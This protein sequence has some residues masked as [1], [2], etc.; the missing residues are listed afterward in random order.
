MAKEERCQNR[1]L[2]SA[3]N[4]HVLQEGLASIY[5]RA[6]DKTN[7]HGRDDLPW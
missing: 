3:Y 1:H 2:S 6:D 5:P 4:M 7:V